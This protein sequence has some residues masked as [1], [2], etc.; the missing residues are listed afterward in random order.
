MNH[1]AEVYNYTP[2]QAS[3]RDPS[4]F[5]FTHQGN[6]HRQ[7]NLIY[8]PHYDHLMNSGLYKKLTDKN[9]LVPHTE[10]EPDPFSEDAYKI[11][12]PTPLQFISYPYEWSFS[13]LKD[14]ALLTLDLQELSL[15]YGMTIKDASAYNLQ[16]DQG[17][18]VF[19]DTLSFALYEEGQPWEAYRQFCQHF[20]APLVLMAKK[21][22]RLG[23][24]LRVYI[25]GIPLDLASSLLPKRSWTNPGLL[26][27]L[28]LHARMQQFYSQ[29]SKAKRR[30]GNQRAA[31]L[32][33]KGFIGLLHSLRHTIQKLDWKPV[34]TEWADYYQATNYSDSS[35]AEKNR[36]VKQYLQLSKPKVV[37]DLG[38]NTGHF[39]RLANEMGATTTLAF[40]VDPAAVEINYRRIKEQGHH[41]PLP[42]LLELTNPTPNLGWS[43]K[44]RDSL[45]DRGPA[46]C[47]MALALIHHLAISNNVPLDRIAAFFAE[48]GEQLI[49]EFVPKSDSQVKRLLQSRKDIFANYTKEYFEKAFSAYFSISCINEVSGSE[50]ILYL[51][52]KNKEI[53]PN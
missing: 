7:V 2:H 46:D 43:N 29:T 40:D 39:S 41:S 38:A 11:L 33:K 49:I 48:I 53:K 44:E 36:V 15:E 21:D 4:G 14:A 3:F 47:I 5:I 17:R 35:F 51:M 8:R 10:M 37:W 32:S 20:L 22:I 1:S 24:L 18:V 6:I 27:H 31:Q 52:T 9:W 45:I 26:M 42:L 12:R 16:F 13:Q 23:Q 19:I 25:D 30:S 34:G 28:H 50:R